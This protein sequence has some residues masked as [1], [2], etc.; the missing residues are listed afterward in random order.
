MMRPK[1]IVQFERVYIA[2]IVLGL[3][4]TVL[5][6]NAT[7]DQLAAVDPMMRQLGPGVIATGTAI[8][9][10]VNLVLLYFIARRGSRIAKWIMVVLTVAGILAALPAFMV[11]PMPPLIVVITFAMIA[12]SLFAVYLLFR[13]DAQAWF[14]GSRA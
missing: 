5:S 12:L 3:L 11:A 10:L 14:G 9:L 8:S 7:A 6:W 4:N 1:S 2:T 13:P